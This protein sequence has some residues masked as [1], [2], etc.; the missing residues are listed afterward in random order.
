M[1]Q[2]RSE[3]A[4]HTADCTE[5][6][7]L[8]HAGA[9]GQR[10]QGEA[11]RGRLR[12]PAALDSEPTR[13]QARRGDARL[14]HRLRRLPQRRPDPRDHRVSSEPEVIAEVSE[15]NEFYMVLVTVFILIAAM[16]F[17]QKWWTSYR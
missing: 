5:P 4:E 12:L 11:G 8:R 9:A 7:P 6:R 15:A 17:L 16:Y 1:P 2:L 10:E 13:R 3:H 14:R